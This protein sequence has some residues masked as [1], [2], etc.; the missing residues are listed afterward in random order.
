MISD[1]KAHIITALDYLGNFLKKLPEDIFLQIAN[2]A[3]NNNPWFTPEQTQSALT[4]LQRFLDRDALESW[5]GPYD[6]SLPKK[7][8]HVGLVM[9]GNVPAVGFHDLICTLL[10]GHKAHV[11][12][13]STDQVLIPWLM[14]EMIGFY[15]PLKEL[16]EF[17]EQ[18][19]GKDAYIA[20]GSD[21][22]SRY[23]EYYF[24]KYPH[25]I[26]KNRTSVAILRG[27]EEK[28]N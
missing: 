13:S 3:Q 11:K 9:A 28:R 2:R 6:L 18:L 21:N 15:P 23:F 26:R 14:E 5:L 4:G 8:K 19:K 17:E 25:I 27:D 7:P 12:L 1:E 22:T 20:T 16:V 24:G 10:S